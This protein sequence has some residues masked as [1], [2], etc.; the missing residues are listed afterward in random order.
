MFENIK[1]KLYK[2]SG[3]P[4]LKIIF[5][6]GLELQLCLFKK[7]GRFFCVESQTSKYSGNK[8]QKFFVWRAKF[9]TLETSSS[10]EREGALWGI[11]TWYFLRRYSNH[12][13][14]SKIPLDVK[15]DRNKNIIH[16]TPKSNILLKLDLFGKKTKWI[17]NK[18]WCLF[19]EFFAVI[20]YYLI[21]SW[22]NFLKSKVQQGTCSNPFL[23]FCSDF[24]I[25][26]FCFI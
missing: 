15:R 14:S 3:W 22:D 9:E 2:R 13:I 1:N 18:F 4:I 12:Q 5:R 25:F 6:N 11:I 10:F 23:S 16:I 17:I 26:C 20:L 24:L 19:L 21:D 8:K 7:G